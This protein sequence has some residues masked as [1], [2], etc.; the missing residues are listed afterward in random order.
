MA[1]QFELASSMETQMTPDHNVQLFDFHSHV[2]R[3]VTSAWL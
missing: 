2:L 1:R 3:A